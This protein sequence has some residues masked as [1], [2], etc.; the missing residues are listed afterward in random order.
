MITLY[1]AGSV[2]G[3]G[4]DRR[5]AALGSDEHGPLRA[6]RAL[7][8]GLE[9]KRR[10]AEPN[11]AG[12]RNRTLSLVGPSPH[13]GAA[14]SS[15]STS[16][17]LPNTP[18]GSSSSS[19]GPRPTSAATSTRSSSARAPSAA[20]DPSPPSTPGSTA[21]GVTDGP[22]FRAVSKGNRALERRLTAGVVNTIVQTAAERAGLV[23]RSPNP[24]PIDAHRRHLHPPR[25]RLGRQP[26]PP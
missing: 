22:L 21:A 26:P 16:P 11:L 12:L 2:I 19:N 24:T 17:T 18:A 25:H 5:L 4:P 6:G 13:F 8:Q 9:D 10:P 7:R 1:L 23:H 15:V 14:S 20:A 3:A